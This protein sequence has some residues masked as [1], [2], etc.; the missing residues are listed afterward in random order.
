MASKWVEGKPFQRHNPIANH[1]PQLVGAQLLS[2]YA[3][4]RGTIQY[5]DK[6][7]ERLRHKPLWTIEGA[8]LEPAATS[9]VQD[10]AF[11]QTVCTALQIALVTLLK[12]W[13]IQPVVTVGHSSGTLKKKRKIRPLGLLT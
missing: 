2:E 9:Q 6:V 8:L 11:S 3:A 1:V 5:L 13:G 4:F 7:L 12:Q 10:P